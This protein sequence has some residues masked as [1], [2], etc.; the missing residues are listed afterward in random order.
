LFSLKKRLGLKGII[1]KKDRGKA[2]VRLGGRIGKNGSRHWVGAGRGDEMKNKIIKI[3]RLAAENLT[4]RAKGIYKKVSN[5][6][7]L[8]FK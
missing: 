8:I 7:N 1:Y 6:Q 2:V 5:V 4:K 3:Y